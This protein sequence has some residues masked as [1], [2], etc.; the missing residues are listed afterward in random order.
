MVCG[1]RMAIY[2]HL[3]GHLPCGKETLVK[4]AKKLRLNQQD[5]KLR[6]PLARLREGE[7]G[8]EVA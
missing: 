2:A 5:H 3:A 4:R 1:V 8:A 7:W 6:E